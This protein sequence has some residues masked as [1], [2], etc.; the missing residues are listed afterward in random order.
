MARQNFSHWMT[1]ATK[2]L[3]NNFRK[4]NIITDQEHLV[5]QVGSPSNGHSHYIAIRDN[6]GGGER[7]VFECSSDTKR[8]EFMKA[9][10]S[11]TDILYMAVKANN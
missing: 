11:I 9:V 5:H 3:E 10:N 2:G 4:L 6:D 1:E 8:S 7:R